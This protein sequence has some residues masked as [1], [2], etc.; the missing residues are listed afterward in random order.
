MG[1]GAWVL[2]MSVAAS[3]NSIPEIPKETRIEEGAF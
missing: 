1:I 2:A 3:T